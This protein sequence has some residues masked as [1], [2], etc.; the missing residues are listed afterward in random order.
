MD[1]LVICTVALIVSALTLFSG[2]GLG[3]LL[4]PAFAIFF[5]IEIAIAATAIVH[6]ANNLFKL[7]LVGKLAN[8]KIVLIFAVPASI[9]AI[10]GALLLNY[11]TDVPPITEYTFSG[12]TFSITVVKIVIGIL[13][14]IFAILELNPRFEKLGFH[15]KYI[16]LGGAL[17]G[18]FGGL[19]G[20]QGALRAAF[21]IRTGLKKESF[22]GTNVVSAVVV[23]ISR[24]AVYGATFVAKNVAVLQNHINI[25]LVFAAVFTAFLGS[26]IGSR[27]MKK[28]TFRTIQIIVGML[29]LFVSIML[30]I[31]LI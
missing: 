4:M 7:A 16:P 11:F 26:F 17:S 3:T 27:L 29:L 22:I 31:G 14:A 23:D 10:T 13:L 5:P 1:Y 25:R 9:M 8:Y 15:P 2:F 19:S 6:L 20:Q 28:I 21:L 30:G 24:L 12:R 18:F